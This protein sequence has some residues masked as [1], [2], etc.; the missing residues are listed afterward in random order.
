[1]QVDGKAYRQKDRQAGGKA[2]REAS[3]LR[4][5]HAIIQTPRQAEGELKD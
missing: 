1:M 2:D 3:R 5:A 4:D